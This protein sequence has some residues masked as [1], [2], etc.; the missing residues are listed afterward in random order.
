ML[1]ELWAT[2]RAFDEGSGRLD[3]AR[4]SFKPARMTAV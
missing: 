1:P 3:R 4:S 2:E